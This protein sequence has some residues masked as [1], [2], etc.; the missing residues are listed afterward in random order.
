MALL[1]GAIAALTCL[2]R[3]SLPT[4]SLTIPLAVVLAIILTISLS[5][6]TTARL[7][8]AL[9]RPLLSVL[10]AAQLNR[11]RF[12]GGI[13]L[14]TGNYFTRHFALDE[15]L[16]IAQQTVFIHAD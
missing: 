2:R 11:L 10:M 16:D 12:C 13:G 1:A 5:A 15:A 3:L 4:R 7:T 14:E 8:I 6:L 9:S